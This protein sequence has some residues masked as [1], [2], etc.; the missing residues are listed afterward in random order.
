MRIDPKHQSD[1]QVLEA[2]WEEL[3]TENIEGKFWQLWDLR[4]GV[5][6]ELILLGLGIA[7]P[8]VTFGIVSPIDSTEY[9]F[10]IVG[11][12]FGT[13]SL[14]GLVPAQV[15]RQ[16]MVLHPEWIQDFMAKHADFAD[17]KQFSK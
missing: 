15:L 3:R 7:I 17:T 6:K 8:T 1:R 14:L 5:R 12:L 4:W 11:I 2:I 13:W 10:G 16:E 9:A